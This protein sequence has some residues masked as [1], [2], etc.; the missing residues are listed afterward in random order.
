MAE[1]NTLTKL[2]CHHDPDGLTSGHFATFGVPNSIIDMTGDEFGSVKGLT[3][4]D[5]MLDMKPKDPNWEGTCIDH[6]F[7]HPSNRKYTLI[8]SDITDDIFS[9]ISSVVPAS[10]ITWN[11]FKDKIPK[12]EW[13]K[14]AIGVNG[15][16]Q[17]ELIPNEVFNMCPTLLKYVSTSVYQ[18]YGQWKIN[19]LP[20]Y[21]V[22]ASGLNAFLRKGDF[23][24]AINVIKYASTP[25]EIYDS[26]DVK[27]AKREVREEF[28]QAV[29]DCDI[30]HFDNL[31]VILFKS[32]IR[33]TGYIATKL[34]KELDN[35]TIMAINKKD[36]SLSMRG[37]L[38]YLYKERLKPISYLEIDG[39]RGFCGGKLKKNYSKLIAD[40]SELL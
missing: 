39:H 18:S 27:I 23:E 2:K 26:E 11:Y 21:T 29:K 3:K 5:W 33:L 30:I 40:M 34:Q 1:A 22:L 31:A 20:L 37:S 13:W 19:S 17:P 36:G 24:A 38:A 14:L 12:E 9:V 16:G 32:N 4:D 35:K 10:Y 25:M 8:P 28:T 7:P 6:H 15:D